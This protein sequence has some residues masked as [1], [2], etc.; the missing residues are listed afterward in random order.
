MLIHSIPNSM[1]DM[2]GEYAG[3]ARTGIFSASRNCVQI[4]QHGSMHDP[5]AT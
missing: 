4:L 3:P 1:G 5:A 2:C